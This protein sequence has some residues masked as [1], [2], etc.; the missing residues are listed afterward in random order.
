MS[1]SLLRPLLVVAL[2]TALFAPVS[3][4]FADTAPLPDPT[5]F[6]LAPAPGQ[7]VSAGTVRV[8]AVAVSASGITGRRMTLDGAEVATTA[9]QGYDATE[10][11][12]VATVPNVSGG[13][14]IVRL[15]VTNGNGRTLAR[16]WRFTASGLSVSRL[17]GADRVGTAVAISRDLYPASDAASIAVLARADDFADAL[18]SVPL[19][20]QGDGPLLLTA[21]DQLAPAVADELTRV[22]PEGATVTLLGGT[23][24]LSPA[25]ETAVT[26]LGFATQRL[27]GPDR[28]ATA[29]AVADAFGPAD[30]VVVASGTSFPD[31]LAISAPAAGRGMP[32]LLTT[33]DGLPPATRDAVSRLQPTSAVVVGGTGVVS[34]QVADQLTG[35]GATVTRIAG[36]N[37]F[38]TARRVA[39]HYVAPGN[40]TAIAS[41]TSF[42]DALAGA[43]HAADLGASLLLAAG[44]DLPAETVT[45]IGN[46]QPT[47]VTVFGGQ[48]AVGAD[49]PQAVRLAVLNR[50]GPVLTSSDPAPGA[51]MN[52]LDTIVLDFDR[53]L[54][55]TNSSV[56]VELGG[57]EVLGTLGVGDFPNTLVFQVTHIRKTVVPNQPYDLSVRVLAWGTDGTRR[58]F[59]QH[60]TYVRRQ[61]SR[62]DEGNEVVWLQKRLGELGY[63]NG[64][65]DGHYGYLTSQA[66]MAFE[67]ANGLKRDGVLDN[68]VRELLDSD[69]R[70]PSTR[71]TSGYWI[72]IDKAR[73]IVMGVRNGKAEWILNTSTGSGQWYTT[74]DGGRA[75][76]VTPS[77]RF[78]IYR[79][80]DGLRDA[81][82]GILWR[83]KYF[84][85]GIALHGSPS[86]PSYPASHGCVRLSN[87]GIDWLWASGNAPIGTRV[88]VY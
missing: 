56:Y 37:R 86:V 79:Q 60:A 15:E 28:Y 35:L 3:P 12:I 51:E 29:A 57:I 16:A 27:S 72:E 9:T 84:N 41:G 42:A 81:P 8:R 7:V 77:G 62:G 18:A 36:R 87:G 80:I 48:A 20:T 65:A 66:V 40:P 43:R 32:I 53:E 85:G 2:L 31:A 55:L 76:A 64:P 45:A 25:V 19:A 26:N 58:Q 69:T 52:S 10:Q 6:H 1:R 30:T 24:A 88:I 70:G 73:Q 22:L 5:I 38:E 75:Q 21:G 17:S 74:S 23:A 39:E 54:S 59:V 82:L 78:Q 47:R 33:K 50:N 4:A 68:R 34:Q 11:Q 14:H 61:L 49:V 13:D 67:K 63:W 71:T 46:L 83:P 44:N